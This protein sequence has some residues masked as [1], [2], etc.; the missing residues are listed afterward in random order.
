MWSHQAAIKT[1]S[2][3]HFRCL[4]SSS[5]RFVLCIHHT[6]NTWTT[7]ECSGMCSRNILQTF[8]L[9]VLFQ[10][11]VFSI[12]VHGLWVSFSMVLPM[13]H[14][15]WNFNRHHIEKSIHMCF[16]QGGCPGCQTSYLHAT[17][18]WWGTVQGLHLIC[19]RRLHTQYFDSIRECTGSNSTNKVEAVRQWYHQ[20]FLWNCWPEQVHVLQWSI[21]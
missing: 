10:G 21:F 4:A 13:H 1:G 9:T 17:G 6:R 15:R 14:E 5:H 7:S 18:K 12:L 19:P 16:I 3:L 20:T 11:V 2:F 8:H